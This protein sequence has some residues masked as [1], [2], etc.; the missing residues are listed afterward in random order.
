MDDS[1]AV[2]VLQGQDCLSKVGTSEL[3]R[4]CSNILEE[5]SHIS[6]LDIL[7]HHVQVVLEGRE[8]GSEQRGRGGRE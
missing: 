8:R 2:N 3:Q 4:Q 6:P 7:H 5:S 1:I